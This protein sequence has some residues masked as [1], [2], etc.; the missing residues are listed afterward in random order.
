M[1]RLRMDRIRFLALI[2]GV[3]LAGALSAAFADGETVVGAGGS[4]PASAKNTQSSGTERKE[5]LQDQAQS[6]INQCSD[7]KAQSDAQGDVVVSTN[8]S[9]TNSDVKPVRGRKLAA[10]AGAMSPPPSTINYSQASHSGRVFKCGGILMEV[11]NH[12]SGGF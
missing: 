9:D 6:K 12:K 10:K 1:T 7:A 11:P 4:T 2:Q 8:K 3:L 5:K